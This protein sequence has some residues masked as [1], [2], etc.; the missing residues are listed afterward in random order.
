MVISFNDIDVDEHI[1]ND[2]Y[3]YNYDTCMSNIIGNTMYNNYAVYPDYPISSMYQKYDDGTV[4]VIDCD[5]KTDEMLF[6]NN[7][8]KECKY[9]FDISLKMPCFESFNDTLVF[10]SR[11]YDAFLVKFVELL[12]DFLMGKY[13]NDVNVLSDYDVFSVYLTDKV[14]D[15]L[16]NSI[17]L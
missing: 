8:D 16:F 11:D 4:L 9:R 3:S 5:A 13:K 14:D 17:F 12:T 2:I 1:V 15:L 7:R 10:N 6:Y